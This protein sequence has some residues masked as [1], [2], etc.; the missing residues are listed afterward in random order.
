M[1]EVVTKMIKIDNKFASVYVGQ[2]VYGMSGYPLG[3]LEE[4]RVNSSTGDQEFW[5]RN[6]YGLVEFSYFCIV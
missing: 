6:D 4:V 2:T 1:V 3:V 5:V